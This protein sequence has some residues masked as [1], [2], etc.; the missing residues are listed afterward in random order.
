MQRIVLRLAADPPPP[1]AGFQPA[2][3]LIARNSNNG[4]RRRTT[5]EPGQ[6][7]P[8]VPRVLALNSW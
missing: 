5:L 4:P 2:D 3:S 7:T 6:L 8:L 1:L